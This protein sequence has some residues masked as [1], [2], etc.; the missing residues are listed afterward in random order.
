MTLK[1]KKYIRTSVAFVAFLCL[2]TVSLIATG[3]PH[4]EDLWGFPVAAVLWLPLEY[5]FRTNSAVRKKLGLER[6]SLVEMDSSDTRDL[7]IQLMIA[8]LVGY[9]LAIMRMLKWLDWF[10]F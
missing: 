3:L 10:S 2:I 1:E 9:T 8:F 4:A 5:L 6:K 7:W